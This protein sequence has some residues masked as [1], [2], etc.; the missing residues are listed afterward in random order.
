[1]LE[2]KKIQYRSVKE[3]QARSA[4][5][6]DLLVTELGILPLSF[7]KKRASNKGKLIT[8]KAPQRRIC[9]AMVSQR[10]LRDKLA[11]SFI[12]IPVKQNRLSSA[13][14]DIMINIG[15]VVPN[16][17]ISSPYLLEA[18]SSETL[19]EMT[20]FRSE[21]PSNFKIVSTKANR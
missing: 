20:N 6:T 19:L 17:N 12:S 2:S 21:K 14:V 10:K 13:N 16:S 4:K 15:D 18:S 5:K 1:M 7:L 8:M 9:K 11:F 3:V